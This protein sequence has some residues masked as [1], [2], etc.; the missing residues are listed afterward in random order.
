MGVKGLHG[1]I[2]SQPEELKIWEK[3]SIQD[4][5]DKFKKYVKVRYMLFFSV[6]KII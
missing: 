4:E 3:I 2:S 1:F 5:I 6:S